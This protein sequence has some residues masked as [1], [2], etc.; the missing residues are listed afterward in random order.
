[1][2][3][4]MASINGDL[5]AKPRYGEPCARPSSRAPADATCLPEE[6][7]PS[8]EVCVTRHVQDDPGWKECQVAR[9]EPALLALIIDHEGLARNYD[10]GLV[11]SVIPVKTARSTVPDYEV[12]GPVTASH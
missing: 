11:H 5:P 8:S 1:M 9:A 10:D 3:A 2:H 6:Y 4:A 12:G 7:Q